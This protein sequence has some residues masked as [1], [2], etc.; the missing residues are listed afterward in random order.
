M[1][2]VQGAVTGYRDAGN[3][4][5]RAARRGA[6]AGDGEHARVRAGGEE[7]RLRMYVSGDTLVHDRLREIPRRFPEIDLAM[8]HLGGTKVLGIFVTMDAEQGLEA[9]RIMDARTTI[10]IHYND[11]TRFESPLTDFEQA[12]TNAGLDDRVRYLAH[13][14][15]YEFEAPAEP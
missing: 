4:R 8:L 15:T 3:A 5:A 9:M 6:P 2:G 7:A 14:E 11:Y 10:P 1:I 12:V 13:G